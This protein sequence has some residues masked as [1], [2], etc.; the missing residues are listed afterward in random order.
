MAALDL[1]EQEQLDQLKAWW[2]KNGNL[3]VTAITLVFLAIAG[4]NGWNYY[5]SSQAGAAA[6]VFEGLQKL[7]EK[8]EPAKVVE[9]AKALAEQ[10]PRSTFAA[11]G[12]FIAAKSAFDANDLAAA[13]TALQW[14]MDKSSDDELKH[15]ARVRLAGVMV[16]QKEFDAALK[17]LE[18]ARPAHFEALYADRRGDAL[19]AMGKPADA[20]GAWESA[21]AKSEGSGALKSAIEFKLDLVGGKALP[22]KS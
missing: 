10:Y 8:N 12:Q 19:Y 5:K 1:E 14:V 9:A 4:V 21:L 7:S 22:A 16:D 3:V 13:R 17:L 2:Q 20:R 18:T 11:M 15:L 6:T